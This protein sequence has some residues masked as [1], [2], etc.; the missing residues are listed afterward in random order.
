MDGD[1]HFKQ[2]SNWDSPEK[3][4]KTDKLKMDLANKHDY[5]VIRIYQPDVLKNKNDWK[6]K[7]IDA[8]KKYKKITNIFIGKIYDESNLKF[9]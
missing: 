5:S 9:L 1:Q 2:I 6:N 4:N 7:L 8:I 3:I